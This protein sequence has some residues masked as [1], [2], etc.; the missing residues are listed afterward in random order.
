MLSL[1]FS[2]SSSEACLL[3]FL[4][5]VREFAADELGVPVF[6]SA[7]RLNPLYAIFFCPILACICKCIGGTAAKVERDFGG[8]V[9]I[10]C[11]RGTWILCS[12]SKKTVSKCAVG[13][14]K[15]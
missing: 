12:R 5:V 8:V 6:S 7:W 9:K 15:T 4:L 10:D 3:T 11:V 13:Y 14:R 1:K 2:S